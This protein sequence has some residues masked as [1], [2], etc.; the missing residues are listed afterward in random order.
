MQLKHSDDDI[1]EVLANIDPNITPAPFMGYEMRERLK[2]EGGQL[3][4]LSDDPQERIR[5]AEMHCMGKYAYSLELHPNG[6]PPFA[7]FVRQSTSPQAELLRDK[8]GPHK[9]GDVDGIS[10]LWSSQAA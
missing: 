4:W 1:N 9:P 5:G 6:H 8:Y 3:F 2:A 10:D 7:E